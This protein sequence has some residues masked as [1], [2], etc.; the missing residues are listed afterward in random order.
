M[1]LHKGYVSKERLCRGKWDTST[2]NASEMCCVCDGGAETGGM[3]FGGGQRCRNTNF[4]GDS[5]LDGTDGDS[6]DDYDLDHPEWCGAYDS[7]LFNAKA[8]CCA[9]GG[10]VDIDELGMNVRNGGGGYSWCDNTN[11]TD[12]WEIIYDCVHTTKKMVTTSS[13]KKYNGSPAV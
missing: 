2:F 7:G 6:C 10:G 8:M 12:D 11:L 1:I 9:C 4:Q 13:R 3:D 5:I